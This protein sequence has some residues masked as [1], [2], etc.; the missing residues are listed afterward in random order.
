[1]TVTY[2]SVTLFIWYANS[3]AEPGIMCSTVC[4]AIPSHS[5]SD[6]PFYMY[7]LPLGDSNSETRTAS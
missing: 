7:T 4:R 3:E 1:M 2:C 5:K 6:Q